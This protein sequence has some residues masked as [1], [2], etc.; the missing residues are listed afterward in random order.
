MKQRNFVRPFTP[1]DPWYEG[2]S[3][4]PQVSPGGQIGWLGGETPQ[5]SPILGPRGEPLAKP[6]PIVGFDPRKAAR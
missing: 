5:Q 4:S 2:D 3:Q 1:F 6:R